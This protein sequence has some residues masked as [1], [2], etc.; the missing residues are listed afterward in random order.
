MLGHLVND[1]T[2]GDETEENND[3]TFPNKVST[4]QA[5]I[6]TSKYKTFETKE[7]IPSNNDSIKENDDSQII[8]D[9]AENTEENFNNELVENRINSY[10]EGTVDEKNEDSFH[11]KRP[12]GRDY[13]NENKDNGENIALKSPF[14]K[15]LTRIQKL[16]RLVEDEIEEFENKRKNNVK[17]M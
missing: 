6:S 14:T 15:R 17:P 9:Q 10:T 5:P 2:T 4:T 1:K 13:I 8:I 11:E 7:D 3:H 12:V 16:Q